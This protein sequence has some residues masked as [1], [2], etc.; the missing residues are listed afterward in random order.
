M[1]SKVKRSR[2]RLNPGE[3]SNNIALIRLMQ[4]LLT[5]PWIPRP[6]LQDRLHSALE[7]PG[8]A[9]V[10][11]S[12][13]AGSG[14]TGLLRRVLATVDRRV[15]GLSGGFTPA[16]D[17]RDR[18]IA[19]LQR[20]GVEREGLSTWSEAVDEL[21]ADL[22]SHR[23]R[24]VVAIDDAPLLLDSDADA[25]AGLT[26]LWT[27]ARAHA[28]P[29]HLVMAG[30]DDTTLDDWIA[31]A[32]GGATPVKIS[33]AAIGIREL[34]QHLS[35]WSP[36]E[37]LLIRAGLGSS[38]AT[39]GRVDPGVRATT[40]LLRLVVDPDGPLHQRPPRHLRERVQKPERYAG[41]LRALA[42]GAREWGEIRRANPTFR[43]GNQLAPYL[44]T[45]QDMGWVAAEQA[46]DAVP[47]SRGRRYHL[48]DPFTAFWYGAVE[49][50]RDRLLEGSRPSRIMRE[51][52]LVPHL[53]R[54]ATTLCRQAVVEGVTGVFP[55]RAR[56]IGGLW[57]PDFD[58][59]ISGIL[60]NGAAF[61]GRCVWN[62]VANNADADQVL[63]GLRATRYGFGRESRVALLFTARG[64]TE[65]LIR[66]VARD[67]RLVQVPLESLF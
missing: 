19:A 64:A 3:G 18:F 5:M 59:P 24:T 42:S 15:V 6:F 55:A 34:A 28:L 52:D 60:R 48:A 14:V 4:L 21:L 25:R 23:T 51:L 54:V 30:T 49:P 31:G 11:L 62:R 20:A 36:A 2:F 57:G 22:E 37:R 12:G 43:S 9:V 10:S 39:L 63:S 46:L 33:V 35:D 13:A 16:P 44:A 38:A 17:R 26:R 50:L 7:A 61:Y 29:L 65:T 47:G 40:N 41:I 32:L 1:V 45:L 8:P 56:Q 58:L 27:G 66:R 67:D 53:G